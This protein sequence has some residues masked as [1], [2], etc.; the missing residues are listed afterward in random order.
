MRIMT[1]YNCTILVLA[2]MIFLNPMVYAQVAI[3]NNGDQPNSNA[4]LDIDVS[5]NDK[6]ILI[7]RLSS[8]DRDA[9][10]LVAADEGL[11]VYDTDTK[12]FWLW[13]GTQWTNFNNS[14][15]HYIGEVFSGGIVICVYPTG[16]HGL[17]ASLDDLTATIG[18]I[19]GLSGTD[20]P[21]CESMT[22]GAANTA[23]IIAAGGGATD[24]AGLCDAYTGG[25][26]DDWYLPSSR[27]LA[28]LF[29]CD[30]IIDNIL[31]ND[32]DP[33]TNGLNQDYIFPTSGRYWG[34][35]E[36]N[37]D[38]AYLFSAPLGQIGNST[39]GSKGRVRA[40]REF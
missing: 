22:D 9:M 31:D 34:S 35:S 28:I 23:A 30:L 4:I 27:E 10:S 40:I 18:A 2:V 25:G 21:N 12:T 13:D 17:M 14:P 37:A 33:G 32:G 11:T 3:N 38:L 1:K 16:E 26:H 36:M 8:S 5:T 7:P 6:G 20:V 15:Q 29:S 24:A 39:K 19:W